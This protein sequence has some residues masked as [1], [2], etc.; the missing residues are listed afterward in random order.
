M[1]AAGCG[2]TDSGS[3]LTSGI[4]AVMAAKTDG[5]GTTSV[6]AELFSGTPDQLIFVKLTDQ[7]QLVAFH[8]SQQQTMLGVQLVTIVEYGATFNS[9]VD[10]DT[11]TIDFE[12]V[13]DAGAPASTATLPAAFTLGT[14]PSSASRA[15]ALSIA[16]SPGGTNDQMSWQVD[17]SCIET[18]I[19]TVPVD[20]GNLMIG[21]NT[22]HKLAGQNIPDTCAATLTITR[23]RA[24]AL[25]PE[26]GKG[27]SIFGEQVRSGT[28]TTTL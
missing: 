10:G 1:L 5:T 6:T 11:F 15:S 16:W 20:S 14:L 9:A 28:F 4:S 2:M 17:G 7:D 21:P 19:G 26:F 12:R 23:T 25:D 24:G 18:S 8:G 3:L 13:I 27:G 22:F